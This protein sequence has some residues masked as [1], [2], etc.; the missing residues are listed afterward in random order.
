MTAGGW[1]AFLGELVFVVVVSFLF[2]SCL[3]SR[4]INVGT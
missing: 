3:V 1:G 2:F 4:R